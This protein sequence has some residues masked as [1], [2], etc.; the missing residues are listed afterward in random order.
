VTPLSDATLR[1][2]KEVVVWPEF[3]SD[4]Y[5]ALEEIGRGGMG[6]VYAARDTALERDVAIKIGNALPD[7]ELHARLTGE[8]RVVAQLEHPGIVSVHDYGVLADG[9]PFYV[10]K[11]VRGQ[12]LQALLGTRPPLAERLRIFERVCEAVSFAHARGVMH[13][14]LKPANVMVGAFGEVI[15]TDWT[16]AAAAGTVVG[17]R[18]FMAPE[19]EA[20]LD[21]VDARADVFSLGV[22]LRSM[23]DGDAPRP[24]RSVC[25]RATEREPGKRYDSVGALAADVRRF[26]DGEAV[27]AHRDNVFERAARFGRKYQV[28]ILL[29]LAY[30]VMRAVIALVAGM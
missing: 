16:I 5:V 15:V 30:I 2:L 23:L 22:M 26:R 25:S 11:R 21:A 8:A 29:V 12:S 9:R 6:T 3:T 10:M 14:D 28:P 24:L 19:Q 27:Q 18:G 17:T 13:R 7:A 4:R 20:G 1:H